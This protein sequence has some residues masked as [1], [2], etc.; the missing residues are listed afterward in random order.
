MDVLAYIIGAISMILGIVVGIVRKIG[1]TLREAQDAI[2]E[3]YRL[4]YLEF[5]SV[6]RSEDRVLENLEP[7]VKRLQSLHYVS[8]RDLLRLRIAERLVA[9][10]RFFPVPAVVLPIVSIGLGMLALDGSAYR[11]RLLCLIVLPGVVMLIGVAFLCWLV[12]CENSLKHVAHKYT[13]REYG[14]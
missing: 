11:L 12:C 13:R 7:P 14:P 3:E 10:A 4:A 5:G 2:K 6:A 8:H 9:T 1:D